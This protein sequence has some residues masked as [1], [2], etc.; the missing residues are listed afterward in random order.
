[1]KRKMKGLLLLVALV[2]VLGAGLLINGCGGAG[3][4]NLASSSAPG[5]NYDMAGEV[6]E[7]AAAMGV[8]ESGSADMQTSQ[9]TADTEEA[10]EA[11]DAGGLSDGAQNRQAGKKLIYTYRYSVETKEFEAFCEAVLKKAEELGGYVEN[12]ETNG[13]SSDSVNRYANMT[14]RMPA[15]KM[16]QMLSM[17]KKEANVTY[18][19]SSVEDVTL[20]YVDLDSHIKAL[21]TEQKT[22]LKL[23]EQA[24]KVEDIIALQ[25]QLTQVRYE[26]ETY[27]SSL[28]TLDNQITYSTVY[29]DIQEVERTTTVMDT[30]TG[31]WEE[32]RNRFGDNLYAVGQGLRSFV[33]WLISSLPILVLLVPAAAIFLFIIRKLLKRKR[34]AAAATKN[35][36]AGGYAT[37]YQKHAKRGGPETESPAREESKR[38][39]K[40][41][42]LETE[43]TREESNKEET[44]KKEQSKL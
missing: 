25:S 38:G 23:I 21:R 39:E 29:L 32:I 41:D 4:K 35:S 18:Y 16:D 36:A 8:E 15:D 5:Q 6:K 34:K 40:Q 10:A 24:K 12:S 37:I 13:S 42:T 27:E 17:I 3:D 44:E 7:D 31:F 26:I 1:M 28:R 43:S 33:I 9:E 22:L 2:P 11:G 14:L 20:D 19:N 30:K